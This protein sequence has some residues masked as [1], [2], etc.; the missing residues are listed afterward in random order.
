MSFRRDGFEGESSRLE[1]SDVFGSPTWSLA[2][3]TLETKGGII[4]C[5]CLFSSSSTSSRLMMNDINKNE[6]FG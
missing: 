6:C 4:V 5:Y 2:V 3:V 1:E